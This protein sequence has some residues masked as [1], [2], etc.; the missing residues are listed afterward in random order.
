MS[1]MRLNMMIVDPQGR[2]A[3]LI[4]LHIPGREKQLV[5]LLYAD[6]RARLVDLAG[7]RP[8]LE[9]QRSTTHDLQRA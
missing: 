6:G 1:M 5:T 4:T 9:Q 3:R 2:V 7:C 8:A